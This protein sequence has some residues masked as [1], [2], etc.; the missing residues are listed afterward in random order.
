MYAMESVPTSPFIVILCWMNQDS[1]RND[2]YI[3]YSL[4]SKQKF[5]K[6]IWCFMHY[7]C[8]AT[9]DAYTFPLCKFVFGQPFQRSSCLADIN[10][11]TGLARYGINN[12]SWWLNVFWEVLVDSSTVWKKP[13]C[14]LLTNTR[15]TTT[16]AT[17]D[18][19]A[20]PNIWYVTP[21]NF[22]IDFWGVERVQNGKFITHLSSQGLVFP[23]ALTSSLANL[24]LRVLC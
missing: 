24:F 15:F 2:C 1:P 13:W 18:P 11:W 12:I 17:G 16:T 19:M 7:T 3:G 4:A 23:F 10:L 8:S 6:S 14:Q 9:T 5:C 22:K 21:W 20:V